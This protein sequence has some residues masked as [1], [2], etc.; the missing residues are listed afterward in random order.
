MSDQPATAKK[1]LAHDLAPGLY[2]VATP[3]GAAR[4]ITLR[5]LDI[6]AAADAI[7]AEDTRTARKLMEI[8]GVAVAGRPLLAY[9]DHSKDSARTRV[10]RLIEEGK[11]VAYV[12]E[13]GTPLVADP[14]YQLAR[15]AIA[16]GLPVTTAP[17]ASAAIAALCL[18]GLPSDRFLFAGFAPQSRAALKSWVAE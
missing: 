17:G 16:E 6:L 15:A 12:S 3:I 11:S 18:S 10:L 2:L 13:A 7:A 1:G 14:G 9:H 8:H 4:D 5:A